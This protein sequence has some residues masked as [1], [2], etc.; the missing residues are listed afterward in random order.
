[1]LANRL[2]I[3]IAAVAG[4]VHGFVNDCSFD[5][6]A[7]SG[8]QTQTQRSAVVGAVIGNGLRQA[9]RRVECL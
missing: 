3:L 1:M 2:T 4:Q 9:H 5:L 8:V 6:S 7:I